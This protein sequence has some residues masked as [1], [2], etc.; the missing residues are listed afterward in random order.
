MNMKKVENVMITV[1]L[2]IVIGLVV[3]V[4]YALNK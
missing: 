4:V 2:V 3:L 1:A